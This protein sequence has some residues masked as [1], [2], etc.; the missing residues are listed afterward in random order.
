MKKQYGQILSIL[1]LVTFLSG[2]GVV[3]QAIDLKETPIQ[4]ALLMQ[5]ADDNWDEPTNDEEQTRSSTGKDDSSVRTARKPWKSAALSLLLPGV[6]QMYNGR[7]TKAKVFFGTEAAFW[8]GF[9]SFKTYANWRENDF[10]NFAAEHADANLEGRDKDFQDWVG[11]YDDI[12]QY[13]TAG[14]I[15]APERPYL[16]DTPENHWQWINPA[17][18]AT[19][20]YIKNRAREAD[21]RADLMIG[22]LVA[23]RVVAAIDAFRDALRDKRRSPEEFSTRKIHPEF[24]INPF[25]PV[26][27]IYVG[28][29]APF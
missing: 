27:P 6:G 21:K 2:M 7:T 3:V 10:I 13:N 23:N 25:D 29:A 15:I 22:L 18:K 26:R 8:L 20:R 17:D 5:I 12:Y 28:I 11:F 14:R 19:Y 24:A 1:I 16:E 9:A 4:D